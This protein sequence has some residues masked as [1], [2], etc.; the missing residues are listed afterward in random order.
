MCRG[1]VRLEGEVYLEYH[2]TGNFVIVTSKLSVG[3]MG[4]G[5]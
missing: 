2:V 1:A 5:M 4:L 3:V